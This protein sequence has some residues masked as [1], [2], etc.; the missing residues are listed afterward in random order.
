MT[1]LQTRLLA[2]ADHARSEQC[3]RLESLLREAAA[4]LSDRDAYAAG[5]RNA[6]RWANRDDLIA[7]IGSPAYERDRDAAL[8]ASE[9]VSA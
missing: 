3:Q 2:A 6:A 5:W 9:A 1:T 7:D 4:V 8:G